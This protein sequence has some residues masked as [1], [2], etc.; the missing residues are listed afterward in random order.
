MAE[1]MNQTLLDRASLRVVL[2]MPGPFQ[3]R[4]GSF[5]RP[6]YCAAARLV[7]LSRA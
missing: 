7:S 1:R 3:D 6:R 4:W 5:V 2:F